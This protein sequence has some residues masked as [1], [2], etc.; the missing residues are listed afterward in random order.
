MRSLYTS[1]AP[2]IEPVTVDEAKNFCRID[3]TEDDSLITNLITA[4]RQAS[5]NYTGRAYINQSITYS[6]D[7]NSL[8][9][10]LP[11]IPYSSC[12]TVKYLDTDNAWQALTVTTDYDVTKRGEAGVVTL[13]TT[14]SVDDRG[15]ATVEVV[16]VAGYGAT[17]ASVP[18]ALKQAILMR[19]A[20]LYERR[21]EASEGSTL[22]EAHILERPY[23]VMTVG[24]GL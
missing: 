4:A 21:S 10:P 5:E 18:Y 13:L 6:T 20:A 15:V 22:D 9:I 7:T 17:A 2:T 19:V 11:K 16:Y 24:A 1:T 3:L 8:F 12:T 23:K 14:P